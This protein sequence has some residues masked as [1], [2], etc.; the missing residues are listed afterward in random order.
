MKKLLFALLICT[1]HICA[2]QVTPEYCVYLV[3]GK[4]TS[5]K[6]NAKPVEVK[7][8]QL[9]YKNEVLTFAKNAELTLINREDKLLVLNAAGSVRVNDLAKKFN[10][11]SPSVTKNYLKLAFRELLEPQRDYASF[12]ARNIGGTRGGASRGDGCDNVIFP[13]SQLKTAEDSINFKWH[14][15]SPPEEYTLLIYDS[16][17]KEIFK[18]AVKDTQYFVNV[19]TAFL[20]KKGKFY[21]KVAGKSG[22]CE[23]DPVVFEILNKADEEK[24]IPNLIFQKG[25]DNLLSQLQII[26][27]LEQDKWIYTALRHYAS[28]TKNNPD[29]EPLLKSYVLFLLKYGFDE[30]ARKAWSSITIKAK[31]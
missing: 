4:V 30:E 17:A 14:L 9:L 16:Q 26:D 8:K 5:A 25:G 15:S 7:Q 29:D 11:T 28:L 1:G 18:A 24:L 27:E 13:I 20:G 21:W 19:Q 6:P 2:A 23:N 3:K 10:A 31:T 12:K 22:N